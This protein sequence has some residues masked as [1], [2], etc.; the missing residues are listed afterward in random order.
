MPSRKKIYRIID[1]LVSCG[2]NYGASFLGVIGLLS[3]GAGFFDLSPTAFR[4]LSIII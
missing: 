2:I 3:P 4:K 1:G